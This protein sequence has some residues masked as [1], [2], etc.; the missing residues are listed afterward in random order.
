MNVSNDK[1]FSYHV[2]A[3]TRCIIP[4]ANVAPIKQNTISGKS[5][6]WNPEPST[7]D[8]M[9]ETACQIWFWVWM[10]RFYIEKFYH[11]VKA[12][13]KSHDP[14][15]PPTMVFVWVAAK[16]GLYI[17]IAEKRS[18]ENMDDNAKDTPLDAPVTKTHTFWKHATKLYTNKCG[19]CD[20][21]KLRFT[22][23]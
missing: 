17:C 5:F 7:T 2:V 1:H 23:I 21:I 18:T 20:K 12:R 13:T 19:C 6:A 8:S 9:L 3:Q 15:K 11:T 4:H 22:T 16:N 10:W 14:R